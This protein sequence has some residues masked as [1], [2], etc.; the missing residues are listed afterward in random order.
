MKQT[1][2]VFGG[3]LVG[4]LL[5]Y[6]AFSW[7]LGHHIYAGALPGGLLGLGAGLGKPRAIWPAILCGLLAT[8]LGLFSDWSFFPFKADD[9]LAFYLLHVHHLDTITLLMIVLGGAIGF[10]V[11]F[12]RR[13]M[14]HPSRAGEESPEKTAEGS[15]L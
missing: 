9:S 10:W 15:D 4:G 5:G 1:L 12:R 2:F 7:L 3:A 8:A 14:G 11:P 13:E 6:L